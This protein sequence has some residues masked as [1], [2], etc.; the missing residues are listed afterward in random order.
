[1]TNIGF[2]KKY[3]AEVLGLSISSIGKYARYAREE[4]RDEA[5]KKLIALEK[6]APS[7][8]HGAYLNRGV[9]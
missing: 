8:R 2:S 3:I 7:P 5:N 1:M 9:S 4:I 6:S